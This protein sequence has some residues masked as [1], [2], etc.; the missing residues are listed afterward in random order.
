MCLR[1]KWSLL[2]EFAFMLVYIVILKRL[3]FIYAEALFFY[4]AFGQEVKNLFLFFEKP[5]CKNLTCSVS[6]LHG[7]S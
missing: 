4:G 2:L 1:I 7:G 5:E 3:P 6:N